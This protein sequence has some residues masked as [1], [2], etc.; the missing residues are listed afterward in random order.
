MA[1][2][3]RTQ[4]SAEEA[5]DW[6]G[7][8]NPITNCLMKKTIELQDYFALGFMDFFVEERA[9]RPIG[10]DGFAGFC[11][12]YQIMPRQEFIYSLDRRHI[13]GDITEGKIGSN[14][15]NSRCLRNNSGDK[16]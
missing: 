6:E 12:D 1:N 9:I 15:V 5:T 10:M 14:G 16:Y 3:S 4:S 7:R 11:I 8:G 2:A 13:L